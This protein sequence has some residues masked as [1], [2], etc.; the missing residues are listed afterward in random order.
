MYIYIYT[1]MCV[2]VCVMCMFECECEC[3]CVYMGIPL[4]SDEMKLRNVAFQIHFTNIWVG[5]GGGGVL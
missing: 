2:C 4:L 5:G 1:H 3:E